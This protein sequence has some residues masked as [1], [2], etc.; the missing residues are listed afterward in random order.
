MGD[1]CIVI[2]FTQAV[3][4]PPRIDAGLA[5]NIIS[6]VSDFRCTLS[7]EDSKVSFLSE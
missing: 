5:V 3:S 4:F 2:S 6:P 7:Q 1:G